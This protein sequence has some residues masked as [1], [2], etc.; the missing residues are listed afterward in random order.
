MTSTQKIRLGNF[1]AVLITLSLCYVLANDPVTLFLTLVEVFGAAVPSTFVKATLAYLWISCAIAAAF[2]LV[3][4]FIFNNPLIR[5][6]YRIPV[7]CRD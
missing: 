4:Q 5:F 1:I 6:F 7:P 3:R 2:I